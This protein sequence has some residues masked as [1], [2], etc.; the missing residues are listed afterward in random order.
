MG[1]L[2][3]QIVYGWLSIFPTDISFQAIEK[4]S[5]EANHY[6]KDRAEFFSQ[7]QWKLQEENEKI[8][9]HVNKKRRMKIFEEGD[10]VWVYVSKDRYPVG[11][12]NKLKPQKIGPCRILRK[13]NDNAYQVE[14]PQGWNISNTFNLFYLY[15]YY[16]SNGEDEEA[17]CGSNDDGTNLSKE[18]ERG[19]EERAPA[20][21]MDE[22]TIQ[23]RNHVYQRFLME[24]E[25]LSTYEA[26][27]MQEG[28]LEQICLNLLYEY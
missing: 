23:T 16:G 4:E 6:V 7:V 18:L 19:N 26:T 20:R 28:E 12:Y 14:L 15:E 11:S 5:K 21:I 9:A 3:F 1:I 25:G 24:W 10:L 27:W 2:P 8:E 13:I 17:A 22:Q